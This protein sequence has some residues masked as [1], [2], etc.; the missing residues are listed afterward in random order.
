MRR[1]EWWE[2]RTET[3]VGTAGFWGLTAWPTD[4]VTFGLFFFFSYSGERKIAKR[5]FCF[6]LF[7][8]VCPGASISLTQPLGSQRFFYNRNKNSSDAKLSYWLAPFG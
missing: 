7:F 1:I 8:R 6:V 4:W 2:A 3:G 5:L